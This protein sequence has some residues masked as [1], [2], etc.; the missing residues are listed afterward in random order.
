MPQ[1]LIGNARNMTPMVEIFAKQSRRTILST[2][3]FSFIFSQTSTVLL[4]RRI[5]RLLA[6][7]ITTLKLDISQ[8]ELT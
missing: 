6:M 4:T 3:V 7:N 2:R 8:F 5:V 1:I